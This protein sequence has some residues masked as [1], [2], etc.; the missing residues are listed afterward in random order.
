MPPK[1]SSLQVL[2]NDHGTLYKPLYTRYPE[3][4]KNPQPEQLQCIVIAMHKESAVANLLPTQ[5]CHQ[6][7]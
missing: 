4:V 7:L 6:T 3:I 5:L 1:S 2:L